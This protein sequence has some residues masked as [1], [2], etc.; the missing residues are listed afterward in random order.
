MMEGGNLLARELRMHLGV[1]N[2]AFR[3]TAEMTPLFEEYHQEIDPVV[4]EDSPLCTEDSRVHLRSLYPLT[5][6]RITRL[7]NVACRMHYIFMRLRLDPGVLHPSDYFIV[8]GCNLDSWES[9]HYPSDGEP[10]L[11]RGDG[12]KGKE[13]GPKCIA[14]E[15]EEYDDNEEEG[16]NNYL[17]VILVRNPFLYIL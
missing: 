15:G 6:S 4:N 2:L 3:R 17:I 1:K 14:Y 16:D 10:L 11:V 7:I 8:K 9:T 12:R 13:C 5:M